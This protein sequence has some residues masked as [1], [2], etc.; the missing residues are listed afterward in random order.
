[1]DICIYMSHFNYKPI[2][3]LT[4]EGVS[5]DVVKFKLFSITTVGTTTGGGGGTSSSIPV[6]EYSYS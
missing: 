6:N 5:S 1:M 4:V 3:K 2:Y